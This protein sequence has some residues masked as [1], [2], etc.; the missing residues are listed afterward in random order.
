M[1]VAVS[2]SPV[3]APVSRVPE[4][5]REVKRR[6]PKARLPEWWPELREEVVVDQGPGMEKWARLANRLVRGE[7]LFYIS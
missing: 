1:V 2:S 7:C 3:A 5:A 4:P 6:E